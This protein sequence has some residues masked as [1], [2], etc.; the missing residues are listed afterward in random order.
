MKRSIESFNCYKQITDLQT[1][2]L[3]KSVDKLEEQLHHEISKECAEL[4]EKLATDRQS[5]LKNI[6]DK[7]SKLMWAIHRFSTKE[8]YID[9]IFSIGA[10]D[11][12]MQCKN[13]M[14]AEQ[15]QKGSNITCNRMRIE[16]ISQV[17]TAPVRIQDMFKLER[18]NH[19]GFFL[20]LKYS[21]VCEELAGKVITSIVAGSDGVLIAFSNTNFLCNFLLR[22]TVFSYSK[23][24]QLMKV[25][26]IP[27]QLDITVDKI[28]NIL[29]YSE[30][31]WRLLWYPL[32]HTDNDENKPVAETVNRPIAVDISEKGNIVHLDN[33]K[34]I[35]KNFNKVN[36]N[37]CM[38]T[39]TAPISL[40]CVNDAIWITDPGKGQVTIYSS[41]GRVQGC[42]SEEDIPLQLGEKFNPH[43]IC[44]NP[45]VKLIFVSDSRNNFV[46][47]VDSARRY[48][49]VLLTEEQG[50]FSPTCLATRDR[51]LWVC[52][53][54]KR[55]SYYE[56]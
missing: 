56:I 31:Q 28:G 54:N 55:V 21:F 53:R 4:K 47:A 51:E 37:S 42:V 45:N 49:F 26:P 48:S 14:Q 35:Y 34:T 38:C 29:W 25:H 23:E 44:Y 5:I 46:L 11:D 19:D 3:C 7:K 52:D 13:D 1:R 30:N 6:S 43:G 40:C 27:P 2:Q 17:T 33:K 36:G 8:K 32:S 22:K 18:Y 16:I 39:L 9:N 15:I 10:D 24:G 50:L 20:S 12:L 41:E